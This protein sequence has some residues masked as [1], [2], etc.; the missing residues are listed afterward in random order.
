MIFSSSL[1]DIYEKDR[2]WLI[3]QNIFVKD[4]ICIKNLPNNLP[5]YKQNTN[6]DLSP[7]STIVGECDTMMKALQYTDICI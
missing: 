6:A 3:I 5:H 4:S 7:D 2:F 1:I